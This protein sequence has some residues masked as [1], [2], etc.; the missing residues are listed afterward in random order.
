MVKDALQKLN[1][2]LSQENFDRNKEKN[3]EL[4]CNFYPPIWQ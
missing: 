3:A 1:K 2:I 4:L